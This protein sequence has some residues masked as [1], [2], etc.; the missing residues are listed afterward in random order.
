MSL[1]DALERLPIFPLPKVQLFPHALLPLHVF[2][3]RYRA[4]VKDCMAGD[5]I[6]AVATLDPGLEDENHG[7]PAVKRVCGVGLVVAHEPLADGRSNI[8]LR[9]VTRAEIL[10]ELPA[11][12][13][14]RA[15][16]LVRARA[17]DD[18][19]PARLDGPAAVKAL[20]LYADRLARRLPAGGETLRG[21]ARSQ[22]LPGP[23]S[24][25]L[26]AALITD[27]GDRQ[28][29]LEE[30]DVGVR[31]EALT[32]KLAEIVGGLEGGPRN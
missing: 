26:A 7:R 30:L 10:D 19:V 16:R 18:R 5:P 29:L 27:A 6:M 13:D 31:V 14:P 8:L 15:Y 9:G 23:L 12:P 28:R 21:L 25:V 4:L 1:A 20:V 24:D 2:E 17:L 32:A 22:P 3:P 11:E